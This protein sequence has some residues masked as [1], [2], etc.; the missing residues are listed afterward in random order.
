[1]A[2]A[3]NSALIPRGAGIQAFPLCERQFLQVSRNV[4]NS[5]CFMQFITS[6][7]WLNCIN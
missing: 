7:T 3:Y 5:V 4:R 2:D 6:V 1:M